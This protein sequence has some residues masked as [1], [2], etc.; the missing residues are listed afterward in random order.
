MIPF[1]GNRKKNKKSYDNDIYRWKKGI[2]VDA[3]VFFNEAEGNRF[4]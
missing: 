3:D 1:W 4:Y 2:S